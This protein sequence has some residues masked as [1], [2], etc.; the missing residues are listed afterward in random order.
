VIAALIGGVFLL[1]ATNRTSHPESPTVTI[2]QALSGTQG[3]EV[4]PPPISPGD[5]GG[6]YLSDLKAL[7]GPP[8]SNGIAD[9]IGG[10]TI[11]KAVQLGGGDEAE[12][13]IPQGAK[14]F[15][16]SVGVSDDISS[17]GDSGAF[18]VFGD[19]TLLQQVNLKRGQLAVLSVSVVG[20]KIL[21]LGFSSPQY[22]K[23]GD[24]GLARFV[25]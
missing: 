6:T 8:Y 17:P 9:T 7:N 3:T 15:L 4:S 11:I 24:F 5:S 20:R 12:Y 25:S 18:S 22:P 21:R 23:H 10:R 13:T 19:A 1:V 14:R 2:L 16:A